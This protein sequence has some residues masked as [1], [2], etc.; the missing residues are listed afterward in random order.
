MVNTGSFIPE[1]KGKTG[2]VRRKRKVYV[3]N[4]IAYTFFFGAALTVAGLFLWSIYL[5]SQIE[6]QSEV[7]TAERQRF[8]QSDIERV[9]E[10]EKRLDHT[11]ALL[12][13]TPFVSQILTALEDA[14][15]ANV[16]IGTLTLTQTGAGEGQATNSSFTNVVAYNNYNSYTVSLEGTTDSF[17]KL[18]FQ[19]SVLRDNS[20][21]TMADVSNLSY[22][23]DTPT[24]S[25]PANGPITFNIT[26]EVPFAAIVDFQGAANTNVSNFDSIEE[27][28]TFEESDF[29]EEETVLDDE[30]VDDEALLLDEDNQDNF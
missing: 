15:P 4:Y 16:Q 13:A 1:K 2:L 6:D 20:V 22:S 8:S 23:T 11:E 25:T 26:T 24:Q 21:L 27:V 28:D 12:K 7:L 30:F 14:T 17:D 19:Q 9:R 18:L 10:L 3:L 29:N 5:D